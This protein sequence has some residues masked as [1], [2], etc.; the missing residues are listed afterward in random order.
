MK[1]ILADSHGPVM[2]KDQTSPNLSLLYIGAYLKEKAQFEV[3]L[4]YIPQAKSD[5]FHLDLIKEFQPDIY[6]VSF[7]SFSALIT[8]E[9]IKKIK[10]FYPNEFSWRGGTNCSFQ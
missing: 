6:A 1:I 2:G 10:S 5:Q 4:E 8:Y 9:L 7:T 3:D